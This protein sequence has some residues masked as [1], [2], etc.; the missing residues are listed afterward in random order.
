MA[1]NSLYS[2]SY[3]TKSHQL[4]NIRLRDSL[5][6]LKT[7]W[8]VKR[9]ET[10]SQIHTEWLPAG[11]VSRATQIPRS[12]AQDKEVCVFQP[13]TLQSKFWRGWPLGSQ[14]P[15]RTC[16]VG[17]VWGIDEIVGQGLWH[18]FIQIQFL[19]RNDSVF[20]SAQVAHESIHWHLPW[21]K[22]IERRVSGSASWDWWG[23]PVLIHPQ[24]N[25]IRSAESKEKTV[26][27]VMS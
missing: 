7:T 6:D 17:V 25:K 5:G 13:Q 26:D 24:T 19:R 23:Q 3:Y 10:T 4:E 8:T 9:D 27:T 12:I 14:K 11:E 16:E 18:V 1:I 22:W 15:H 20:F 21:R 2:H